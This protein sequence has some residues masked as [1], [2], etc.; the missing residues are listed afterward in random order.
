MSDDSKWILEHTQGKNDFTYEDGT[1]VVD[2]QDV[3]MNM[4]KLI[5]EEENSYSM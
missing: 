3:L 5:I 2:I 4:L 1:K